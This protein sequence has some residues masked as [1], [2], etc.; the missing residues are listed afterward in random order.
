MILMFRR[1]AATTLAL[2]MTLSLAHAS[3]PTTASSVIETRQQGFK[4]MGAAMK[5]LNEQLKS[6]VPDVAK[7]AASAQ[8]ISSSAPQVLHWFPAGTGSEAGVDTDALDHIWKDRAKFDAIANRLVD[9]SRKLT[10]VLSATDVA[11]VKA[12]AKA[13]GE[14]CSS[15]HKSFRAD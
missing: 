11:A 1:T 7:M 14:T 6:D 4:K 2:I 13:V 15:C 12:Q 8:T 10:T 9:E 3:D 5:A